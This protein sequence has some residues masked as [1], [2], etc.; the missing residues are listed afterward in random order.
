MG[1]PVQAFGTGY[2]RPRPSETDIEVQQLMT[3]GPTYKHGEES[4]LSRGRSEKE[5]FLGLLYM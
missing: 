2:V 4:C 3:T 1:T 5:E